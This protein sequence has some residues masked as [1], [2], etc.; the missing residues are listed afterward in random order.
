MLDQ[1]RA[2]VRKGLLEKVILEL[3]Y[4]R[5]VFIPWEGTQM[6]KGFGK[7]WSSALKPRVKQYEFTQ[8]I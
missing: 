4:K 6:G 7:A 8:G 3:N 5:R 2:S 1:R